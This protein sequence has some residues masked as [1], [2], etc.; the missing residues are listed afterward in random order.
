M[1]DGGINPDE[2]SHPDVEY[3]PGNYVPPFGWEL[4]PGWFCQDCGLEI[5]QDEERP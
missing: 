5:E 2:C 1:I 3:D 4:W